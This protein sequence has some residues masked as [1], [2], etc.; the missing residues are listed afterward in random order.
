[1]SAGPRRPAG[2]VL[3][4]L[5]LCSP[6]FSSPAAAAPAAK[7][8]RR[9]PRRRRRAGQAGAGHQPDRLPRPGG[10]PGSPEGQA[11]SGR[12]PLHPLP[13][14]LPDRRHQ[15]PH[16][17]RPAAAAKRPLFL[18]VSVDPAHDTPASAAEFNRHHRTGE[19]DWLLG[20]RAELEKVWTA[21]GVKP[22]RNAKDPEEIE[23]YAEIFA[24][25]PRAGSG[26]STRRTSSRPGWRKTSPS[27]LRCRATAAA[28]ATSP[29]TDLQSSQDLDAG[30]AD[31][32]AVFTGRIDH[33]GSIP[34]GPAE[35]QRTAENR[36][37]AGAVCDRLRQRRLVDLLRARAGRRAR[38]GA[39]AGRLPLRRRALRAD[40]EDLRR[41]GGDVP[42]GGRLLLLRPPR[43]QRGRLLHRGLGPLARLHPHDRDQ[44]L[45]RPPLPG[46]VLPGARPR[47]GGRHRRDR[48]DRPARPGQ[49]PRPRRVGE[50]QHRPRDPRPLHPGRPGRARR[51]RW[52]STP[53]CSSTRSTSAPR[54]ASRS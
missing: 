18:A 6:G 19:I 15:G 53:R 13:R 36:R 11:G 8:L 5:P 42:R 40:R 4:P 30:R 35:D 54:R 1:M 14:P 51:G 43:V 44:R 29:P 47:A 27:S 39:D 3:G 32:H 26:P 34:D 2:L 22:E 12:L 21:W 9:V 10:R 25:D 38:A 16:R 49:H 23:H 41:G 31:L 24:I 46:G 50:A 33:R 45:L 28:V 7:R 52:S 17:F 20:S 37:G 48:R